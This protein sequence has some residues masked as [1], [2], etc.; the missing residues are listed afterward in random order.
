MDN[1]EATSN[2]MTYTFFGKECQIQ[3]F[4]LF[5][6]E[7]GITS[8]VVKIFSSFSACLFRYFIMIMNLTQ[9]V[10]KQ[11]SYNNLSKQ[12]SVKKSI[13]FKPDFLD[14]YNR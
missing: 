6:I 4:F 8:D 14:I 12:R 7:Y 3:L 1:V 10:E 2:N 9:S 13:F 11:T 5:Q